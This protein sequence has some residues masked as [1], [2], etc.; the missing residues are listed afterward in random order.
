M[1]VASTNDHIT[2][3]QPIC[4]INSK[5]AF[6]SNDKQEAFTLLFLAEKYEQ[7]W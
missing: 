7:A 2:P 3:V 4:Q 6:S 5:E 1:K